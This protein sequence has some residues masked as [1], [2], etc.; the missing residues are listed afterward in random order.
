VDADPEA[1]LDA[2]LSLH[3][4]RVLGEDLLHSDR[5]TER[6]LGVVLVSDRRSEDHEDR[7][8]D[9]LLDGAVVTER[10]LGEVLEDARN[11]HLELLRVEILGKR[12]ESHEVGKQHR[13]QAAL[14]LLR[15]QGFL[16]HVWHSLRQP[17]LSV[18][19]P[20]KKAGALFPSLFL[21]K[22]LYRPCGRTRNPFGQA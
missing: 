14:L 8:A 18:N 3:P 11:E 1:E 6:P 7:V 19:L 16:D 13:H 4:R 17:G 12:C 15:R 5:A 20:T 22:C 10:F 9:E 2:E 21:A